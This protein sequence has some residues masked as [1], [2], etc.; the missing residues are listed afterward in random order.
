VVI[1]AEGY[2]VRQLKGAA[3]LCGDDTAFIAGPLEGKT[4]DL[5]LIEAVDRERRCVLAIRGGRI[6][7]DSVGLS[8][9]DVSR[10]GPYS[11]FK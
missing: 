5:A 3:G 4:A 11:N 2:D 1:E 8:I 10:A 7:F 6:V 9:P